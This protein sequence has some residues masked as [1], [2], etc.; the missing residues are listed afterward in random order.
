MG[1]MRVVK[2]SMDPHT[3]LR[4]QLLQRVQEW[5]HNPKPPVLLIPSMT[6]H[7][8]SRDATATAA[9]AGRWSRLRLKFLYLTRATYVPIS[10][11][12]NTSPSFSTFQ[13][14]ALAA[15]AI[16]AILLLESAS[17]AVT[18]DAVDLDCARETRT[19]PRQ[20]LTD[21]WPT[22]RLSR[23]ASIA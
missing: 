7:C 23:P 4:K 16:S 22:A 12:L 3:S 17:T 8:H 6:T 10:F 5:C 13:W 14:L 9:G 1:F 21:Y 15:R 11:A 20:P 18:K 2:P 19:A